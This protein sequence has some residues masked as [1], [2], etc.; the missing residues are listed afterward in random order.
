MPVPECVSKGRQT[1]QVGMNTVLQCI[2]VKSKHYECVLF[3]IPVAT[4]QASI[5]TVNAEKAGLF[6]G[7]LFCTVMPRVHQCAVAGHPGS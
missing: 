3:K 6:T 7:T 2:D 4:P 5:G 1:L